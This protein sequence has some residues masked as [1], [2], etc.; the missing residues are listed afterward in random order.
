MSGFVLPA[1]TPPEPVSL[2]A[3]VELI[4][5]CTVHIACHPDGADALRAE[6]LRR[7]VAVEVHP[8]PYVPPGKAYVFDASL[9]EPRVAS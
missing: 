3:I 7:G 6:A 9:L 5:A 8:S 4:E 1:P 2:E